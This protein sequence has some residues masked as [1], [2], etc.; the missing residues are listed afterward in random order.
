MKNTIPELQVLS[1]ASPE[2]FETWMDKNHETSPGIWVQFYKK[3]SGIPT[4]TYTEAVLTAL[5]YGWIDSQA[6]SLDET[7]YL[8]KFTPRRTKSIW[9]AVNTARIEQLTKAGKMKPAGLLQVTAAKQDGRWQAAYAPPSTMEMPEE[10]L[11]ALN[12]NEKAK[13]FFATLNKTNTYAIGWRLQTAKKP[14]TRTKR[15]ALI[16]G[17][18][19][20]GEKFHG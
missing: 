19:E 11:T 1:F 16:I 6:K 7:S 10:F 4:I 17:M 14:E 5:C 20:R 12:A 15:I 9:S 3:A 8:Q 2:A 13:A 18:L